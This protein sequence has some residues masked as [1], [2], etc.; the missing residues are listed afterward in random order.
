MNNKPKAVPE[1][2]HCFVGYITAGFPNRNESLRIIK[3]CCETGLDIL[4]LGFPS[5]DSSMDG[6]VIRKAQMQVDQSLCADLNFWREIRRE[7]NIPIWLMGYQ[8]DLLFDDI[9]LTLAKE[10]LYDALVIP[11]ADQKERERLQGFLAPFHVDVVGFINSE[12]EKDEIDRVLQNSDVIY[13]QL[14]C[15]KTG[16]AHNDNSYLAL[17]K[18]ARENSHARLFAGFGIN[19][20]QRVLE[21]LQSG[22]DGTIIGSA[23][24]KMLETDEEQAY[25]FIEEIHNAVR[26]VR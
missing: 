14:Y 9:Y 21:L 22:Y 12:M 23:I 20:A 1:K 8:D 15:G 4:E 2:N 18:Y 3:K 13:H 24:M 25:R 5:K 17:L 7:I 6:E 26:S 10:N 16:V 11:D 19:S